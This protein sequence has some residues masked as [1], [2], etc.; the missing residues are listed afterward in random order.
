MSLGDAVELRDSSSMQ[1]PV[2]DP[3]CRLCAPTGQCQLSPGILHSQ[4]KHCLS[5]QATLSGASQQFLHLPLC[6]ISQQWLQPPT[7]LVFAAV[8]AQINGSTLA[9]TATQQ[10]VAPWPHQSLR[11][12][13]AVWCELVSHFL[14]AHLQVHT[15]YPVAKAALW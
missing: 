13:S 6:C 5:L 4:S 3:A 12:S 15:L 8:C 7:S 14:L 10:E 1:C 2:A 11:L 9:A